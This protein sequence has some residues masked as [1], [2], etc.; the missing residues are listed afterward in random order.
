LKEKKHLKRMS[1]LRV[2]RDLSD[3]RVLRDLRV[4]WAIGLAA[5]VV[6]TLAPCGRGWRYCAG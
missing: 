1:D 6:F 4:R 5:P 3:L 2:L